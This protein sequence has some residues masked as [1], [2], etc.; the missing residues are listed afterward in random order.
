MDFG[1][2]RQEIG[3][4]YR[5]RRCNNSSG[6]PGHG[7]SAG[8]EDGSCGATSYQWKPGECYARIFVPPSYKA[9]TAQVVTREA[10]ERVEI[11][12]AR[13]EKDTEQIL[14]REAVEKSR[15]RYCNLRLVEEKILV[16]PA[17]ERFV[18]APGRLRD[19][20][21]ETVVDR[22]AHT[23]WKKGT[24]PIQK[25]DDATGEIHVSCRGTG[26]V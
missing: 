20:S 2:M 26:D 6:T 5:N 3:S 13:Y 4:E 10:S 18:E 22:P 15:G 17:S 1:I 12:P 23:V 21:N 9:E 14:V 8:R 19:E 24:G 7:L 25:V 16:K 11:I